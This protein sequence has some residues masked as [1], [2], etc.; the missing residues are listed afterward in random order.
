M[1]IIAASTRETEQNEM[2]NIQLT[3]LK[4]TYL[5]E[6]F[7]EEAKKF[8]I[9]AEHTDLEKAKSDLEIWRAL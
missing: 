5:I 7:S 2:K 1:G 4:D 8:I 3:L 9:L 6:Q